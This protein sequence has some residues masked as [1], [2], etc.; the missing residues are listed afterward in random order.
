VGA[1]DKIS[2]WGISFTRPD[3]DQVQM[4]SDITDL[5]SE[6]LAE[7]F[8]KLT[9]WA[10]YIASELA[11]AQITERSA[12]RSLDLTENRLLVE[13]MGS[14]VKGERIT[15]V[16]AQ[17]SLDPTLVELSGK[18]EEAYAYRKL[19]EMLLS[20]HE[21]DLALVSREITRRASDQRANRKDYGF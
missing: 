11:V 20:N 9:A 10:D 14:A 8:T 1:L 17:I 3:T 7:L 4:P 19:V 16:K 21:R 2:S 6:Q 5:S 13:R 18:Y 12:Q 15:L